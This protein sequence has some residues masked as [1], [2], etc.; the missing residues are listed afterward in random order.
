MKFRNSPICC[1]STIVTKFRREQ[2]SG[3]ENPNL[4]RQYYDVFS[5]LAEP[6]VNAF[7]GTEAYYAHKATRFTGKDKGTI[8]Q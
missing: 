6:R 8:L 5:L 2:E 7:I 4:M 1:P 3:K